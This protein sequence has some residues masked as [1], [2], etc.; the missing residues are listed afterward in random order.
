M[1]ILLVKS[2]G[3]LYDFYRNVKKCDFK[4]VHSMVSKRREIIR[5][6]IDNNGEVT[7]RDLEKIFPGTSNMT[8]RRDLAYLEDMGYIV[9]TRGGAKSIKCLSRAMEDIYSLRAMVNTEAKE[10][11]AKKAVEFVEEGRSIFIDSGT[12]M[13]CF[14]RMLPDKNLSILTCGPNIALEVMKRNNPSITLIGGQI[15]RNTISASG[16]N[17][18]Y[19]IKNVNIDIAF[20]ATS[21]F[22][23]ESGFTSGDFNECMLKRAVIKKARK[24]ILLMDSGKINKN[25]TFTFGALKDID[26][27]ICERDIPQDIVKAAQNEGVEINC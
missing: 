27:L 13:M 24:V 9:R 10:I 21:G 15:N 17:S 3:L 20:M 8:I 4:E 18:L 11:I 12:T 16:S 22:S 2:L 26:I 1:N 25:M 7:V 14:A 6:Y 23:L 19:F 5:E